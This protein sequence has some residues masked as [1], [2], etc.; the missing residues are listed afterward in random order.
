MFFVRDLKIRYRQVFVGLLWVLVQPTLGMLIFLS[1]FW[2][3]DAKPNS[4]NNQYA[5]TASI[6]FMGMLIWQFVSAALRDATG[7]LVNYRH[8][9]TKIAFPRLL[10]PLASVCCA[11]FD[12]L[13]AATLLPLV[14]WL[15]GD[16]LNWWSIPTVPLIIAI[17]LMF[18]VGMVSWLA[19]LNAFY[20]DVG[21][22]LP[23][24]IQ[25]GMFVS[26]VIYDSSKI[27]A[28]PN[29]PAWLKIVYQS[30]PV[31]NAI[32][33]MRACVLG[34]PCPNTVATILAIGLSLIVLWSG[35]W[36]FENQ[37]ERLA[38]RI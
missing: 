2:L 29:L 10:L 35:L 15:G 32:D 6:V 38:D 24:A 5:S 37:N 19:S 11:G 17:L 3:V 9:I 12:M 27:V 26:P 23:F 36:W 34:G 22:A 21:Y 20:R 16:Q 30:N 28:N 7:S 8:V 1:V 33:W 25:I 31:A 14:V 4:E 18:V 13:V